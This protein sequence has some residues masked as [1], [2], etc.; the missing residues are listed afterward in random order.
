MY[1]LTSGSSNQKITQT[2]VEPNNFSKNNYMNPQLIIKRLLFLALLLH[3]TLSL[4]SENLLAQV[5]TDDEI[6][7]SREK[8]R[9][10]FLNDGVKEADLHETVTLYRE[11]LVNMYMSTLFG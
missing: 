6:G 8:V 10:M 7:F 3:G 9:I 2:M 5:Y 1:G 11:F 4:T